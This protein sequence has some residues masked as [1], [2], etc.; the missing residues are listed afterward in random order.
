MIE[1]VVVLDKLSLEYLGALGTNTRAAARS[2]LISLIS[3]ILRAPS[4]F[5]L[6]PVLRRTAVKIK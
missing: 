5:F 3:L 2:I 4:P 1:S 6:A